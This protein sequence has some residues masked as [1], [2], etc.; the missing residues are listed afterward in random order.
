LHEF[1]V[2]W[3]MNSTVVFVSH[4][5][6]L[7]YS[8]SPGDVPV[9]PGTVWDLT[10]VP[11]EGRVPKPR[12]CPSGAYSAGLQYPRVVMQGS[13][14]LD[15]KGLPYSIGPC[16]ES[17]QRGGLQ[18]A[19]MGTGPAQLWCKTLSRESQEEKSIADI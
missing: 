11:A 3:T 18:K 12:W 4:N 19:S 1:M 9:C 15:F 6:I 5:P 17:L 14:H 10:V 2:H 13:L 16:R 7:L 8:L